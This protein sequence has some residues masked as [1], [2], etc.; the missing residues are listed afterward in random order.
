VAE[1]ARSDADYSE[2]ISRN[3]VSDNTRQPPPQSR[4]ADTWTAPS[5]R[6]ASVTPV[7]L[8]RHYDGED[9]WEQTAEAAKT[10][11]ERIG[12]PRP[13]EVLL[14]PVSRF[15]GAPRRSDFPPIRRKSDGGRMHHSQALLVFAEKVAGPVLIGAGR[16]RG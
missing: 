3:N 10:A 8:D 7:V 11:C 13:L 12:L 2:K 1:F 4:Q 14:H 15:E 16:F 9:K 6:W 5:R